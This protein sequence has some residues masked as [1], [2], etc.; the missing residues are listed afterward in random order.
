MWQVPDNI[1]IIYAFLIATLMLYFVG[2][3]VYWRRAFL[4]LRSKPYNQMRMAHQHFRLS[5]RLRFQG[6][7]ND[8]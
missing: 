8:S 5:V 4:S 6:S 7:P 2:T 1:S 3:A